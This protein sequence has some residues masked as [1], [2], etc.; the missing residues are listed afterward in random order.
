MPFLILALI[1]FP[2]FIFLAAHRFPGLWKGGL[3]GVGIMI[4]SDYAGYR[5]NLY[6][7]QRELIMVGVLPVFHIFD[8]FIVS[9]LF[10]NWLPQQWS[11]RIPYILFFSAL[12]L[13][14]E[15]AMYNA[16]AIIYVNWHLGYSYLVLI[17]G[18]SLLAYLSDLILWIK[19]TN[20]KRLQ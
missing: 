5:L 10:L 3:I 9:M 19:T 11:R 17:A 20:Y 8:I 1:V 16:G 2:I 7:Y 18:L 14:V 6:A 13:A 12:S 4:L 15:G